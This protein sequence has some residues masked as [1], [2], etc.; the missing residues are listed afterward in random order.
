MNATGCNGN[1]GMKFG[2]TRRGFIEL[3][4]MGALTVA[5]G[6]MLAGCGKPADA[7]SPSKP[8]G[9]SGLTVD[10]DGNATVAEIQTINRPTPTH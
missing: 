3:L 7:P 8:S 10:S 5:G 1:G 4:S 9:A 6:G 2:L